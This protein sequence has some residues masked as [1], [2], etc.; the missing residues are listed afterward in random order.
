MIRLYTLG[1]L[2]L[3]AGPASHCQRMRLALL[4]ILAAAGSVGV[5]RDRLAVL[6][7]PDS[8]ETRSRGTL[9][10]ALHALRRD[11]GQPELFL[12][13]DPVMLN[14][15]VITSDVADFD[16]ALR[17]G[18]HERAVAEYHG[19]FLA[20][21]HVPNVEFEAW[22]HLEQRKLTRRYQQTVEQLARCA[23]R[24]GDLA[25]AIRWWRALAEADPLSATVA[26]SL[27]QALAATGDRAA[28]IRHADVHAALVHAALEA[29]PDVG[30]IK[31]AEQLRRENER[32]IVPAE[33]VIAAPSV[34]D[35]R[36]EPPAPDA[37]LAHA[38]VL[39]GPPV[40]RLRRAAIAAASIASLALAWLPFRSSDPTGVA[41]QVNGRAFANVDSLLRS[42]VGAMLVREIPTL[43]F[44]PGWQR[45]ARFN[46]AITAAAEGDSMWLSGT[47]T[48]QFTDAVYSITP[49]ASR[50]LAGTSTATAEQIAVAIEAARSPFTQ[51]WAAKAALPRTLAGF[52]AFEAALREWRPPFADYPGPSM[53]RLASASALDSTSGSPLALRALIL[54]KHGHL[55]AADSALERLHGPKVRREAWDNGIAAVVRAWIARDMS[56]AH[57]AGHELLNAVPGSEWAVIPSYDALG[58]GYAN[59][60]IALF[61][62]VTPL[63]DMHGEQRTT[64]E[65][66]ASSSE[67]LTA[68]KRLNLNQAYYHLGQ[69][70]LALAVARAT[71]ARYPEDRIAMQS[72]IKALAGLGRVADVEQACRR[73]L[74]RKLSIQEC[75]QGVIELRGRGYRADA[76]RIA[77]LVIES[78]AASDTLTSSDL[79]AWKAYLATR[80]GDWSAADTLLGSMSWQALG[81]ADLQLEWLMVRGFRGDTAGVRKGLAR[82][83][84]KLGPWQLAQIAAMSGDKARATELVAEGFRNGR[85]RNITLFV[86][87]GLDLLRDYPPFR[88]LVAPLDVVEH[89]RV[90]P[91]ASNGR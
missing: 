27:M 63:R 85:R 54:A 62:Q 49:T 48:D 17:A 12:G 28:A 36:L 82:L 68:W 60:A 70:E 20:G 32:T 87:P 89:Q 67:A 81:A 34:D 80:A 52:R 76:R 56:G 46:V 11:L 16:A 3:E 69:F 30:V 31:L 13:V 8:D 55:A 41:L 59:E 47:V 88:R 71:L 75:E 19:P 65:D 45:V 90:V 22:L 26:I 84:E 4:A 61:D 86:F 29:K 37:E 6:L 50:S 15:A 10:Q 57:R 24:D 42:K 2:R 40:R 91:G 5:S 58:L 38:A 1:G 83:P 21:F 51:R 7:W 18:E 74:G 33:I 77:D 25:A 9:K 73:V 39:S 66:D 14:P 78:L 64:E 53:M 35:T 43:Q 23:E 79:H 72:A 44:E